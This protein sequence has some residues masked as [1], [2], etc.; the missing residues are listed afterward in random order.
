MSR[1]GST[2]ALEGP[3]CAGKSTLGRCLVWDLGGLNIGYVDDYADHVG[4]GR[5]LPPPMPASLAEEERALGRLLAIEADRTAHVR[6]PGGRWD[7]VILDRSVHT[8]LAHCHALTRMSGLDFSGLAE[9]VVNSSCAAL[10][11]DRIVYL[12]AADSVIGARNTGK[13]ENGSLFVDTKFNAGF[14]EY[15]VKLARRGD[16]RVVWLDAAAPGI[17]LAYCFED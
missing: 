9:R 13:F 17:H 2:I 11:P 16:G 6:E 12:D 10:W 15:F 8:L 7:L 1:G 3:V 5:F 4:G 14:R